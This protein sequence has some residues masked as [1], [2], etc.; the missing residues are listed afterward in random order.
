MSSDKQAIAVIGT[1]CRF[2]GANNLNEF[3]ALLTEGKNGISKIPKTRWDTDETPQWA[4]LV[5]DIYHFDSQFFNLSPAEAEAIDPQ[6]RIYY[7]AVWQ[8]LENA[9]L[10]KNQLDGE[11]V[12]VFT[13]I[14]TS[15]YFLN[16]ETKENLSR[17]SG[18]GNAGSI[19]SNRLSYFMNWKGP[20][21]SIDTACSSSLVAIH[22]ACQSLR[23]KECNVAIAGGTNAILRSEITEVFQI[24]GMMAK[25]GQCKTFDA[26]ADGYVRAE[27]AGAVVLK[28]LEDAIKDH[29][30]ILAVIKG[31]AINQDGFT[32]GLTAPNALSQEE[33]IKAACADAAILPQQLDYI[34]LHGT[35]TLLGDPIEAKALGTVL[36]GKDND[37]LCTVGS[38]K[39]NIGHLEAAAGIASFI[40]VVLSFK[41]GRLF[42]SLNYKTPNPYIP[43]KELPFSVQTSLCAWEST[44]KLAGI[45]GFGFGGTNCHLI[46]SSAPSKKSNGQATITKPTQ[47]LLNLS[48][49]S[50]TALQDLVS[51]YQTLF[52][53]KSEEEIKKVCDLTNVSRTT[54]PYR[55]SVH[56]TNADNFIANLHQAKS[57]YFIG[58]ASKKNKLKTVFLFTGQGS[59]YFGMAQELYKS[60]GVFKSVLDQCDQELAPY[61]DIPLLDILFNGHD[62]EKINETQYAQPAIVAIQLGLIA[63][64]KSL[65]IEPDLV[66]GHSLGELTAAYVAGVFSSQDLLK[67][68]AIRGKLMGSIQESGS[69]ISIMADVDQIK[70]LITPFD[71]IELAAIN[72]PQSCVVSGSTSALARFEEVLVQQHIEF[73]NLTVSTAFHS[74]LMEPILAEL[75]ACAESISTKSVRLNWLST[76]TGQLITQ[77]QRIHPQH[78]ADNV[79][80]P[81]QFHK[82]AQQLKKQKISHAIEI[83]PKPTLISLAKQLKTNTSIQFLAAMHEA[84]DDRMFF[85]DTISKL[86]QQ[87]F[88]I[89]WPYAHYRASSNI[90]LPNYPFQRKEFKL[91]GTKK[92]AVQLAPT[93]NDTTATAPLDRT[94]D[95]T[96]IVVGIIAKLLKVD[97]SSISTD[98]SFIE[99]GADSILLVSAIREV[100][101]YFQL[102]LQ[103]RQFFTDLNNIQNLAAYLLEHSSVAA[104]LGKTK[105][106]LAKL[107]VSTPVH[108]SL[109]NDQSVQAI[110]NKQLDLMQQQI[111]LLKNGNVDLTQ[112]KSISAKYEHTKQKPLLK[113]ENTVLP[114]WGVKQKTSSKL[115]NSEQA[116]LTQFI[117]RYTAKTQGSKDYTAT[118]RTHLADNRASAG[119]R[120]STKDM[121][122]PIVSNRASGA[123]IWD[124][125]GNKYIDISMGFGVHLF[126]HAPKFVNEAIHAQVD[127]FIGLGPQSGLSGDA[128]ALICKITGHDRAMFCNSGTEA[129]MT[130]LRLSRASRN[131]NKVVMFKNSYHGHF[132]GTLGEPALTQ[133]RMTDTMSPGTM[134]GMVEDLIVLDYGEKT[135]LDYIETRAHEIAAV[136][137]EPVQ[138]RKPGLQPKAFLQQLRKITTQH[139]VILIFD[140]MITGFRIGA[141]GAQAWFEVEADIA[142]Y[143]KIVGGGLPIG[144]VAGKRKFL[145]VVDG[146]QWN[147]GDGSFPEVETSF[148]A[149]TFCKHP[150]TLS[151]C[152]AVLQQI[153]GASQQLYETLNTKTAKLTNR[154]NH[155]FE[156]VE[157]PFKVHHFGSLFRFEF[158][159][160]QD[161]FFYHLLDKGI[162][163]W[164]GRNCFLSTAHSDEDIEFIYQAITTSIQELGNAGFLTLKPMSDEPL[165]IPTSEAQ[166][167]LWRLSQVSDAG[168]RAYN[169]SSAIDII[170]DLDIERLQDA[171]QQV[172]ERHDALRSYLVDNG[173]FQIVLPKVVT[174]L[175]LIAITDD[176]HLTIALEKAIKT[177]FV[178][179]KAPLFRASL[180]QLEKGFRFVFVIHHAIADGI[181][182]Q[183]L[184]DELFKIYQEGNASSIPLPASTNLSFW[185]NW[186]KDIRQQTLWASE[187]HYW[188]KQLEGIQPLQLSESP[189]TV[190]QRAFR[191]GRCHKVFN[192]SLS[193]KVSN[194]AKKNG[195]TPFMV[196]LG[197]F[198]LL[199]QRISTST[200]FLIGVP[201][202]G[203]NFEQDNALVAYCTHL[204][205]IRYQNQNPQ[206]SFVSI[207]QAIRDTLLDAFEHP[208]FPY[209]EMVKDYRKNHPQE[210]QSLVNVTFNLDKITD[211]IEVPN[212]QLDLVDLPAFYSKFD[213]SLNMTE[214]DSELSARFD[215]NKD[216]FEEQVISSLL[217]KYEELLNNVLATPEANAF[218]LSMQPIALIEIIKQR[219]A[220]HHVQFTSAN[221]F[222]GQ[223]TAQVKACPQQLAI[224][225]G[226]HVLT[227]Q[228]LDQLSDV[229]AAKLQQKLDSPSAKVGLLLPRS[230]EMMVGILAVLKTGNCFV[231]IDL[232]PDARIL[233]IV[234]IAHCECLVSTESYIPLA[235]KT[236]LGERV[237]F[238][239][240]KQG[241]GDSQSFKPVE[242]LPEQAAYVLFTSGSEGTPKAV[243][244]SHRA[245]NN[246]INAATH[247][248]DL[249]Q[250]A[251]YGLI[252]SFASDLGY[253]MVFPALAK[254]NCLHILDQ[255]LT[256]DAYRLQDYLEVNPIDCL[257]IVPSHLKALLNVNN[258]EKLL[259]RQRLILGGEGC[260]SSFAAEI[261]ALAPECRIFNHY[262]PTET[263]IGVLIGE[264][265]QTEVEGTLLLDTV[266]ANNEVHL[267]DEQLQ[268]VGVGETGM[269]YIG[270]QNLSNGYL[271]N[272][273]KQNQLFIANPVDATKNHTLYAT[274]D[275]MRFTTNGKLQ[276][277]GR[278][279]QQVKIRGHRVELTEVEQNLERHPAIAQAVV[280]F[281]PQH[282]LVAYLVLNQGYAEEG[283]QFHQFLKERL[284]AHM[285]PNKWLFLTAFPIKPNGKL[286]RSRLP[287]PVEESQQ[288]S[289]EITETEQK[290]LTIWKAVLGLE[291]LSIHDQYFN[292]GGDSIHSIQIA[293][294]MR[295]IGLLCTPAD[296]YANPTIHKLAQVVSSASLQLPTASMEG[297]SPL[298]PV[299]ARF[300]EHF[301]VH[302]NHW[303]MSVLL[304]M[305]STIS[306][307]IVQQA[308][309]LLLVQHDA[310]RITFTKAE[311]TWVQNCHATARFSFTEVDLGHLD[312]KNQSLERGKVEAEEQAKVSIDSSPIRL[313]WFR[314]SVNVHQ[315]FITI[316]HLLMDAVS[317]RVLLSD[318]NT[319]LQSLLQ[320]KQP[321]IATKTASY[322]N[323]IQ[324]LA[325]YAKSDHINEEYE[326]WKTLSEIPMPAWPFSSDNITSSTVAQQLVHTTK[327]SAT[328]TEQ[329]LEY[330]TQLPIQS[331]LLTALLKAFTANTEEELLFLELE[332]H[333][334]ENNS[335]DLD[336]SR[337]VG[338]FTTHFPVVLATEESNT[339]QAIRDID[340]QLSYVPNKGLSF[341]VLKHLSN[342]EVSLEMLW[343]SFNY[344][345]QVDTTLTKSDSFSIAQLKG[346]YERSPTS[347]LLHKL[348]IEAVIYNGSL[349]IE[350]IYAKGQQPKGAIEEIASHFMQ[351]LSDFISLSLDHHQTPDLLAL[352]LDQD[353][354][355]DVLNLLN[356]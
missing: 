348:T 65:G 78:W 199:L 230:Y 85:F 263:T 81:V 52:E 293:S 262:G 30:P 195:V 294:R 255:Q 149:G 188:S 180:Y 340:Q 169:I 344:L 117:A 35:G 215:Y 141:G 93:T 94:Q 42:P 315:L 164:E 38:V 285:L 92:H 106:P 53:N 151:S 333:G 190:I 197:N 297:Q 112:T 51:S 216:L 12:G 211:T 66:V 306:P 111:D 356:N 193:E 212:L 26:S 84:V 352:E 43:F 186:Q 163:I 217:N 109:S 10:T 114:S 226:E 39:S 121:L 341:G 148:F 147:Y 128:A 22:L 62:R 327:L 318:F 309:E 241:Q 253:T 5:D 206:A 55:L 270:G 176:K 336:V 189:T 67:L 335:S 269:L 156:T 178:L 310:L 134:L 351:V 249:P 247:A 63:L 187:Q 45:S 308:F 272:K 157:A 225:S 242:V 222:I 237:V 95:V 305:D 103:V 330:G 8:A 227:Y 235:V 338:W 252:S 56:D 143:G 47:Y 303:N 288:D 97:P 74:Y 326:Y 325:D 185:A 183:L 274:G 34:E 15:D 82:C 146:G 6:Q 166:Q 224:K 24:A 153:D 137:V 296:L 70:S 275:L 13:G 2:P 21:L 127:Q 79:R 162:Y 126:G 214:Y 59:Q 88:E 312:P 279:D 276:W 350:W 86:F 83:G 101:S 1:G 219:F 200:N 68:V 268:P 346:N 37:Q 135:S 107:E 158:H 138:S 260:D 233:Q 208:N 353:E 167:Q 248:L 120:F 40:K 160:N 194:F 76:T 349:Q 23:S 345:G 113:K 342:E 50:E 32:N 210:K 142:T 125:D 238:E 73:R 339:I 300:F 319:L 174:E 155:F 175:K 198:G 257:K 291:K 102:K 328:A 209:A 131:L 57:H 108:A 119:F 243:E 144:V 236:A 159:G 332:S 277:I 311:K 105:A 213:L 31:S 250:E 87:G 259:P 80:E 284:P 245:L 278:K 25:D 290:V 99:M 324:E 266:L 204:L 48:A 69:M 36:K 240:F 258:P 145:D 90:N 9:Y 282:K 355:S 150:L 307:T 223:F 91:S 191:G 181:S 130:A 239:S 161:L 170:G 61:L 264:Y 116:Y 317:W 316:H 165:K 322:F 254:G 124:L 96:A 104:E 320:N 202:A 192:K 304:D 246:Y 29:D 20:S 228:Q 154:L 19:A 271:N 27:G 337:T 354:I 140:E 301:E 49:K 313:T 46:V 139:E 173:Q 72:G 281:T 299:Q 329:L 343:L 54:F 41:Y 323:W 152:I 136:I 207:V 334:R 265:T 218:E 44:N 64:Y 118:H 168:N 89:T 280:S 14:S 77:G 314:T 177:P 221:T 321:L 184:F 98:D 295:E 60:Q 179:D 33:V 129:V 171:L 58:K 172:V 229:L 71:D 110:I 123:Y 267:L 231:P 287:K 298:A 283:E 203:R 133:D 75:K 122:Y 196:L 234:E 7:E 251:H 331:I 182:V 201:S 132:D 292:L 347:Q 100:E 256:L 220:Q 302:P 11:K 17:Y 3:L 115:N 4:G 286:D 16:L 28:R 18:L 232:Q 261:K 273:G 244:I 205:P 289:V